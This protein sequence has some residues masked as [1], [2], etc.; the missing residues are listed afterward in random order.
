MYN[1]NNQ[2]WIYIM[3]KEIELP[4]RGLTIKQPHIGRILNDEKIWELRS[5]NTNIRGPIALIQSGTGLVSG[6]A[7]IIDCKKG[8]TA[9]DLFNSY[10]KHRCLEQDIQ[11]AIDKGQWKWNNAWILDNVISLEEPVPYTHNSGAVIWISF[12]EEEL[13]QIQQAY[14]SSRKLKP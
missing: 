5:R 1:P 6:F 4:T 10:S 3:T 11:A 14:K 7:E 2:N 13:P 8:L 12:R 9:Q